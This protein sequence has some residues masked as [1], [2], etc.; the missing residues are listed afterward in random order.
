MTARRSFTYIAS[1]D[2]R[3]RALFRFGVPIVRL[4]HYELVTD[5]ETRYYTFAVTDDERLADVRSY[6][7]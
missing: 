7:E 1:D 3:G 5:R 2:V 6:A 4:D